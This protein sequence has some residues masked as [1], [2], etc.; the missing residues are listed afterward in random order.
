MANEFAKAGAAP[1]RVYAAPGAPDPKSVYPD[2]P[3]GVPDVPWMDRDKEYAMWRELWGKMSVAQQ[4]AWFAQNGLNPQDFLMSKAEDAYG[5]GGG[6]GK[7]PLSPEEQKLQ[8]MRLVA[9][10]YQ[11][12]RPEVEQAGMNALRMRSQ[13]LQPLQNAM[14]TLY[15]GRGASTSALPLNMGAP[16]AQMRQ[17]P[18]PPPVPMRSPAR[19]RMGPMQG[20]QI[21]PNLQVRP[22]NIPP[23]PMMGGPRPMTQP[24]PPP[25][26]G[27]GIPGVT[28]PTQGMF[29]SPLP[30]T[31]PPRP[32]QPPRT[33]TE[34]PDGQNPFVRS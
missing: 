5:R 19:P 27:A 12:R 6:G 21:P 17:A 33:F 13:S 10:A 23:P 18:P 2:A 8:D 15:G 34:Y 20:G 22:R 7:A 16:P 11:D 24:L 28:V 1:E 4:E 25:P 31:A 14:A 29:N 26:P 30:T 32:F 3:M 9:Q